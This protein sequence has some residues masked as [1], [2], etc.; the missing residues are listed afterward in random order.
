M[1]IMLI[2]LVSLAIL[3]ALV[4]VYELKRRRRP[5]AA[6]DVT[7]QV[8]AVRT[9]MEAKGIIPSGGSGGP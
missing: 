7:S 8:R 9:D 6:V 1:P 4:L 3:A 5:A 2:I